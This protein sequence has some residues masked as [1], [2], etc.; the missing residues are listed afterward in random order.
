MSHND[1]DSLAQKL[2]FLQNQLDILDSLDD[3][4]VAYEKMFSLIHQGLD[5]ILV[6]DQQCYILSVQS[7]GTVVKDALDPPILQTFAMTRP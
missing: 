3:I 5:E 2:S 6:K 1:L 4:L 7:N